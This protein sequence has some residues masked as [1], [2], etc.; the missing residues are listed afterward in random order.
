MLRPIRDGHRYEY[1]SA[2]SPDG[3]RYEYDFAASLEYDSAASFA[4]YD[5]TLDHTTQL[6]GSIAG[7]GGR[8]RGW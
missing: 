7:C 4:R 3:H 8:G 1:H 2:A 5:L 6:R